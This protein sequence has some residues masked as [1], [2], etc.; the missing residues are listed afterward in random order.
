MESRGGI[1]A[2]DDE[3]IRQVGWGQ[4]LVEVVRSLACGVYVCVCAVWSLHHS[5]TN[6]IFR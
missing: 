2:M 4:T 1:D 6:N 5:R 3:A